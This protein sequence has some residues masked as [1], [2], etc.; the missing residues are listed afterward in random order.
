MYLRAGQGRVE[1]RRHGRKRAFVALGAPN[2]SSLERVFLPSFAQH[3]PLL[4]IGDTSIQIGER[5]TFRRED[6]RTLPRA[7]SVRRISARWREQR[8]TEVGLTPEV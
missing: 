8:T 1:M 6:G 7:R 3:W 4:L 2:S 5:V